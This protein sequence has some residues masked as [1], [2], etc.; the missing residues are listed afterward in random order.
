[1]RIN[2]RGIAKLGTKLGRLGE[3]LGKALVMRRGKVGARGELEEVV[4]M[5]KIE[6]LVA[7]SKERLNRFEQN[8]SSESEA[9]LDEMYRRISDVT[10]IRDGP[11]SEAQGRLI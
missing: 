2:Q 5:G 3:T 1:M 7:E 10:M 6:R 11:D 9:Q 8:A 4:T